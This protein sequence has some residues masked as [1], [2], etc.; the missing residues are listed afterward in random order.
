MNI[1]ITGVSGLLGG[2]L[3]WTLRHAHQVSGIYRK[4]PVAPA[5]VTCFALDLE[6][7]PETREVVRNLNPDAVIHCASRTDLDGQESDPEGSWRA[8]VQTTRV[9]LD[10]LRDLPTKVIHISTD[11]VYPGDAGPYREDHPTAPR[12]QYG[13]T[14]LEAETLVATRP[15]SLILRTNIYGWN[16]RRKESLAEMFLHRLSLGQTVRG[17]TDA[18]F[19]SIYVFQLARILERCLEQNL[20]GL[21][22]AASRD[23]CSK[24]DFGRRL[25]QRFGLDPGLVRPGT[26]AE[27]RLPAPRGT[28]LSLDVTRLEQA[29]GLPMPTMD[30]GLEA[31]H[32]D[33]AS[34]LPQKLLQSSTGESRDPFVYPRRTFTAYGG[35]YLDRQDIEA[36]RE[37]LI[38]SHLTQGPEV[39]RFEERV[40]QWVGTSTH[41]VAVNSGTAGLH[42]ACLAA[43]V[44]PG[45]EVVTSPITFVASANAAVYCGA[46][47]VFADVDPLFCNMDPATLERVITPRTKA[48]IPV[49]FAGQSCD[50]AAL[51]DVVRRKSKE[52]DHPIT[53]IEDACH[54]LGSEYMEEQVGACPWSEMT[55]FSFHPVKHITTGE[56]GMVM[57]RRPELADRLRRLRS[58]GIV[59]P[60]HPDPWYY[61]QV[62]LGFNFRITDIQCALGRSQ[63]EKLSW[64][65]ER[66]RTI[67]AR[68]NHAFADLPHLRTP[69][70]HPLCRSN[71]H[72]YV[73]RIDFP[74]LGMTR[75]EYMGRLKEH[76]LLTQVHYIPVHFHPYYR[77]TFGTHEGMLPVAEAFYQQCLSL[78]LFPAMSDAEVD[79]VIRVVRALHGV[80][81]G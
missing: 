11:S 4:H 61:E 22:N 53:L 18:R 70:E 55:V 30:E 16:Q 69:Q 10:A 2:G 28:D 56:G 71:Y 67:V 72:L 73:V 20:S 15:G 74:A 58:H 21:Y 77:N 14:K 78:P 57:T 60:D 52:F 40:A 47:P 41:A 3:A 27:A 35:Q 17:F 48:V 23:A 24:F 64:F 9:L 39:A 7:Y 36:V 81:E 42:I 59:R 79:K 68:Y 25:A 6:N 49:H 34:G 33:H 12:N 19:S 44:G 43:G 1:L 76:N 26:L 38:S 63:M 37:T 46:T 75:A 13:R 66:R 5:G 65:L 80:G 32:A 31:F 29:L 62:E 8:N 54:A 51:A 50:M 45:D